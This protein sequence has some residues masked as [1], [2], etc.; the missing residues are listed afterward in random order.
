MGG[1]LI[2][3]PSNFSNLPFFRASAPSVEPKPKPEQE[4]NISESVMQATD[5]KD[6]QLDIVA[7]EGSNS[8]SLSVKSLTDSSLD[9]STPSTSLSPNPEVKLED[10]ESTPT[11]ALR[12][13]A[14]AR[15]TG[16][17]APILIFDHTSDEDA[18]ESDE[19]LASNY[20]AS[21]EEGLSDG[22]L[23]PATDDEAA[24]EDKFALRP[25]SQK[26]SAPTP[27]PRRKV[28]PMEDGQEEQEL[29]DAA[30]DALL[31]QEEQ[32]G[33]RLLYKE[34]RKIMAKPDYLRPEPLDEDFNPFDPDTW[35][36][37][38]EPKRLP[39]GTPRM[40]ILEED[41]VN[42][43]CRGAGKAFYFSVPP[44][45]HE[46]MTISAFVRDRKMPTYPGDFSRKGEGWRPYGLV[47]PL[48]FLMATADDFNHLT[49]PQQDVVVESFI[50]KLREKKPRSWTPVVFDDCFL[51]DAEGEPDLSRP[52]WSSRFEARPTQQAPAI[53]YA[54]KRGLLNV[55]FVFYRYAGPNIVEVDD[56][57]RRRLGGRKERQIKGE[58]AAAKKAAEEAEKLRVKEEVKEEE[59]VEVGAGRVRPEEGVEDVKPDISCVVDFYLL[60]PSF[61][62]LDVRE[63]DSLRFPWQC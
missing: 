32:D 30:V 29:D 19:D 28:E 46:D 37:I 25:R 22:E 4:A 61:P 24:D 36:C 59:G 10:E 63:A 20:E 23:E 38:E 51:L 3:P 33:W 52:I 57:I 13:S 6:V 34:F 11:I 21:E 8:F 53:R 48:P 12:R 2:L 27:A 9:G 47:K 35:S 42:Y 60:S 16:S 62:P 15:T 50:F 18:I 1:S 54:L 26:S 58:E 39:Y 5:A 55:G 56:Y 41:R 14:R 45:D 43:F 7:G 49:S 40:T 44:D 31:L 17:A